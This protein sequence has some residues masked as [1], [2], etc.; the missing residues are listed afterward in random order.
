MKSSSLLNIF[1]VLALWGCKVNTT[2]TVQ[3][4]KNKTVEFDYFSSRAKIKLGKYNVLLNLRMKQDS[5]VW[6]NLSNTAVGKIGKAIIKQDSVFVLRDY[7]GKE[8]YA[9]AVTSLQKRIGYPVNLNMLTNI[10][11]GQMPIENINQAEISKKSGELIITQRD[12]LFV[13]ENYLNPKTNKLNKLKISQPNSSE[14]LE[15]IYSDY[16]PVD[17]NLLPKLI[18][19][20][21]NSE[22]GLV[23]EYQEVTI[24]F[25]KSKFTSEPISFPFNVTSKYVHK[26]L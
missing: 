14:Y 1:F 26:T 23:G 21:T 11:L 13:L 18:L 24:S 4:I 15:L 17:G 20:R 2:K 19:I 9:D 5:A 3:E 8:Y 22:K 6:I 12:K 16:E 7:K 25:Q 10:F